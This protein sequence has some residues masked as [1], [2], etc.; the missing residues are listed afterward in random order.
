[1]NTIRKP[2]YCKSC[3]AEIR[4]APCREMIENNPL[5]CDECI[6]KINAKLEVRKIEK[7]KQ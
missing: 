3:F 2:V 6:S 7:D 4:L 1:M 5:L